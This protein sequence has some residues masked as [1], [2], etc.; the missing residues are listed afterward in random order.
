VIRNILAPCSET[1]CVFFRI[2]RVFG[3][4]VVG[5]DGRLDR[6]Q[7]GKLVFEDE[8]KRRQLNRITH[9]WIIFYMMRDCF[10]HVLMGSPVIV[11]DVPLLFETKHLLWLCTVTV[12]VACEREQQVERLVKRNHLSREE[13]LQ[14]IDSQMPLQEKVRLANFVVDNSGNLA[15]LEK[16]VDEL[17][18]QLEHIRIRRLRRFKLFGWAGLGAL[19]VIIFMALFRK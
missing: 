18:Q 10:F 16:K 4:Q 9:P 17:W 2:V 5:A 19:V 3:T 15:V 1:K 12:V 8:T 13:A 11:L 14:R 6:T 7:L